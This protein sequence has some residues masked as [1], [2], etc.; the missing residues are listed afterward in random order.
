[1]TDEAIDCLVVG[2]GP[3]GLSAAVYLRRF[4]R[5]IRIVD[6]G[7]SRALKIAETFNY[8]GFPEGVAGR[9]LLGRLRA[10]LERWGGR[11]ARQ[12]VIAL[13][14]GSDGGFEAL[15]DAGPLRA[16]TVLLAT[17]VVDHEPAIPGIGRAIAAGLVRHCPICDG[18]EHGNRHVA[19]VG[20]GAH[21]AREALFLRQFGARVSLCLGGEPVPAEFDQALRD[22]AVDRVDR[23]RPRRVDLVGNQ[24]RIELDDA[25]GASLTVDAIY[26]ALGCTPQ[27]ALAL[28]LGAALDANG[29]LE[30]DDHCE[31]TVR[32]LYAAG[33]VVRA[34]DQLVVA[35]AHG[36]IAATGIHN[37]LMR[38]T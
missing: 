25:A 23:L 14:H 12:R 20:S 21:G 37:R 17:G 38:G 22:A 1:M 4:H 19:V 31:T 36:A 6:A 13:A 8:P 26:A 9:V 34:I 16:R 32:G 5:G 29:N 24:V 11:V 7:G 27:S 33:D 35:A 2:A 15:T 3:A 18:H 30:V 28:P 10:Q